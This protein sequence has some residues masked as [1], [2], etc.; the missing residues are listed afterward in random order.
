MAKK[1][2]GVSFDYIC[3][4]IKAKKFSPVYMLMGEEPYFIDEIT[5]LLIGNVLEESE[6]D[7]NQTILYG[8]DTD[9]AAI[10]NAA[11]RFPMMAERQL[12]V[13]R[14]AQLMRDI[15]AL[16]NYVKNPLRS[17]VLVVNHK[18]KTLDGRKSLSVACAKNGVLFD[19]KKIK[20]YQVPAFITSFLKARATKIDEKGLQMLTDFLG[21]DLSRLRKELDKLSITLPESGPKFITPELIERNTGISKEY[22]SFELVK[23]IAVK[24]VFKANRIINYFEK[25]PKDNPLPQILSVLF[26]YFSNLFMCHYSS[27]RSENGLMNLL[28]VRFNAQVKDYIT[29]LRNYSAMKV[30]NLIGDIRTADACSKGVDKGSLSDADVMKELL[31][32]I[33]H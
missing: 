13:V 1:E 8:A 30:F 24:D 31:Y 9:V 18:Y 28:E 16:T 25:N 15:E 21:N 23:A 22:N 33:L 27:D 10:Y 26:N 20:D 7:F 3:E 2:D 4:S 11:R 12:V 29:G 19:S 14:E 17:T 32:K 5:D 6:R